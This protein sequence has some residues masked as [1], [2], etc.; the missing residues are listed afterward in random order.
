MNNVVYLSDYLTTARDFTE[1]ERSLLKT[2]SKTFAAL[3][4]PNY[5]K[6]GLTDD[7]N[8]WC[9]VYDNPEL[10]GDPACEICIIDGYFHHHGNFGIATPSKSL[11]DVMFETLPASIKDDVRRRING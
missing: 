2:V 10:D 11:A 7:G 4:R 5:M 6:F 3:Y 1:E 8:G 9:L